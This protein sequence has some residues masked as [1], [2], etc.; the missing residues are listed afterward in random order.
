MISNE[1][2]K[3]EKSDDKVSK[4]FMWSHA[5]SINGGFMM[6]AATLGSYFSVYMTDT[7]GKQPE[8]VAI[9]MI[10]RINLVCKFLIMI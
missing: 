10:N 6:I 4:A 8:N 7:I 1:A 2:I 3:I 9:K 5:T